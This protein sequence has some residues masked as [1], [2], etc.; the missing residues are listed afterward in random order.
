MFLSKEL[1][2]TANEVYSKQKRRKLF[3]SPKIIRLK[4]RG[5]QL[6][7]INLKASSSFKKLNLMF[8][9]E[10]KQVRAGV[11]TFPAFTL[12]CILPQT[13]QTNQTN[14]NE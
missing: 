7:S 2:R 13:S 3:Q 6:K 9:I 10:K 11:S 4:L 8:S 14:K 12:L 1:S 5:K